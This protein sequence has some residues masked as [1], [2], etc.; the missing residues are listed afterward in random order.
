MAQEPDKSTGRVQK[1][2]RKNEASTARRR[3]A[4]GT[5]TGGT[6]T[7]GTYKAVRS[8]RKPVR[9]ADIKDKKKEKNNAPKINAMRRPK[10]KRRPSQVTS[11]FGRVS[12]RSVKKRTGVAAMRDSARLSVET[13]KVKGAHLPWPMIFT[14]MLCTAV[15]MAMVLNYVKLNEL[16]NDYGAMQT[17]IVSLSSDKNTLTLA[18]EQKNNLVDID[19]AAEEAGMVKSDRVEKR[20][21]NLTEDDKIEVPES[22]KNAVSEFFSALKD[23]VTGLVRHIFG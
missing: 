6:K 2:R 19:K 4:G 5:K 17:K 7:G 15:I 1:T 10:P 9:S 20:Y 13:V 16:S 3:E 14:A 8:A 22:E 21:I 18:L 11:E 12:A 23:K